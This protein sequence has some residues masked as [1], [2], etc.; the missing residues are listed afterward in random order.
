MSQTTPTVTATSPSTDD[1]TD[2]ERHRL[3]Q[4]ERRRV[5]VDVLAERSAPVEL[6]AL[7]TAI[8]ARE[9][10]R[11]PGDEAAVERI[12]LT[13]HHSH[14]PKLASFDVVDYDPDTGL[15]TRH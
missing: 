1:L 12:E 15:V 11:D 14:L 10:G 4:S 8:A 6:S 5:A 13:L 2:T 9:D 7:A 3:L